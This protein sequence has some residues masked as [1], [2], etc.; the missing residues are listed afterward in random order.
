M[1]PCA[2]GTVAKLDHEQRAV[3]VEYVP[4]V[5]KIM[6]RLEKSGLD[7]ARVGGARGFAPEGGVE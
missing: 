4:E 6:D 1:L 2:D 5:L 3:M 7:D